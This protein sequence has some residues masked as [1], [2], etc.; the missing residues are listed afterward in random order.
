MTTIGSQ[1]DPSST[2]LQFSDLLC[3]RKPWPA[4]SAVQS[5]GMEL[6][7]SQQLRA[8]RLTALARENAVVS[9]ILEA[10][11]QAPDALIKQLMDVHGWAAHE[12]LHAVEQL[13]REMLEDTINNSVNS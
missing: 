2:F 3:R 7:N 11:T 9:A 4:T 5:A 10:I 8:L 13:Q 6:P 12:A 1:N